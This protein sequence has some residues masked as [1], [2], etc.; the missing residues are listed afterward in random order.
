[1][2]FIKT[3]Y[4]ILLPLLLLAV[5]STTRLEFSESLADLDG[6]KVS[7]SELKTINCIKNR[8]GKYR[9][10]I[11]YEDVRYILPI[12]EKT[13]S[14]EI[15]YYDEAASLQ[16]FLANGRVWQVVYDDKVIVDF[17]ESKRNSNFAA[18]FVGYLPLV[19]VFIARLRAYRKSKNETNETA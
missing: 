6:V 11:E 2:N 14:S 10:E 17:D 9:L 16:F 18:V 19:L 8:K 5:Y 15:E 1:M 12:G 3:N 4:L 13:C 7:Y